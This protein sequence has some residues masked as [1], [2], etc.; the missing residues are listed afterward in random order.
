[1]QS[2]AIIEYLD[3]TRPAPPLL[4]ADPHHRA[5]A[6]AVVE[7]VNAG[8]QPLH[9]MPVRHRLR[10]QFG[11]ADADVSAWIAH[12]LRLRLN[13]LDRL[14]RDVAGRHAVGDTLGIADVYLFPQ[15]DKAVDFGVDPAEFPTI[16]RL[17]RALAPLPAFADTKLAQP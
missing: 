11:A 14:L 7:T 1:V 17:Y 8:I 13:G 2:V 6:R 5:I 4:P 9:N 12:W 15:A 3:E 16:H 10:S